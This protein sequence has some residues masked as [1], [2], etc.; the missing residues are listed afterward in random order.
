MVV[1][2]T[3]NRFNIFRAAAAY[4]WFVGI[5]LLIAPGPMLAMLAVAAPAE[6][7]FYRLNGLLVAF[8]G[9]IYWIIAQ[10]PERYRPFIKLGVAGKVAVF[11][12]FA[13]AWLSGR[14]PAAAFGIAVGD[15]LFG[16]MFALFLRVTAHR[17]G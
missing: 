11:M 3:T 6:L 5:P 13:E 4:N 10:A 12:L 8:F 14:V 2:E 1:T 9:G 7:T 17:H 15:L 16:I